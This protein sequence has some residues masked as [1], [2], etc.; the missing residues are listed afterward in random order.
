MPA[1]HDF[2]REVFTPFRLQSVLD[3][4]QGRLRTLELGVGYGGAGEANTASN[5]NVG[6]VGVF[7]QKSGINLEFRGVNVGSSKLSV[8]LDAVNNEIDVDVVEANLTLNN[9]GGTLSTTK[10][11]TGLSSWTAGD[12]PYYASGTAL[13]KLAIGANKTVMQSNGSAPVWNAN[14][15]LGTGTISSGAINGQTISSAANFTGSITAGGD[16]TT[17][18]VF[19]TGNNTAGYS[20]LDNGATRRRLIA[21]GS[22]NQ[23]FIGSYTNNIEFVTYDVRRLTIDGPTGAATFSSSIT[24]G[25]SYI[26]G[27]NEGA[28]RPRSGNDL[29]VGWNYSNGTREIGLWNT[30][31]ANTAESFIFRQLTGTGT[32]HNTLLE[33]KYTGNVKTY[34]NLDLN[35]GTGTISSG[36]INGQTISSAANFTG[37]ITAG[38]NVE[39]GTKNYPTVNLYANAGTYGVLRMLRGGASDWA[40]INPGG[41]FQIYSDARSRNLLVIDS[42]SS[43]ATFDGSITAGGNITVAKSFPQLILNENSTGLGPSVYFD[44]AGVRKAFIAMERIDGQYS[45]YGLAGNLDITSVSGL[46]FSANDG[47][48]NHLRIASTGAA[49]FNG[50]VLLADT[51]AVTSS[52]AAGAFGS[53]FQLD[54]SNGITNQSSLYIDNVFVRGT[55]RAQIFEKNV[56]RFLNGREVVTDSTT[57]SQDTAG[58][59]GAGTQVFTLK[60]AAFLT[61]D[62]VEI[63]DYV[64][65]GGSLSLRA[66][67]GYISAGSGTT[68]VTV[69]YTGYLAPSAGTVW[70]AGAVIGRVGNI[71]NTARQGYIVMDS[72]TTAT[73]RLEFYA[74]RNAYA[75]PEPVIR[76]GQ[77]TS[78]TVGIRGYI[79]GVEVFRID[80]S[81]FNLSGWTG[82]DFRLRK[83][84]DSNNREISLS[85]KPDGS[86]AN[87]SVYYADGSVGA[88]EARW[89]GFGQLYDGT[90][91][92]SD[93]GFALIARNA[94]NSAYEKVMWIS[95][96]EKVIDAFNIG[97]V[98]WSNQAGYSQS[99]SAAQ[100]SYEYGA[101]VTTFVQL[102]PGEN[103]VAVTFRAYESG[104]VAGKNAKFLVRIKAALQSGNSSYGGG[105]SSADSAQFGRNSSKWSGANEVRVLE[106][107]NATIG[108]LTGGKLYQIT[109]HFVAVDTNTGQTAVAYVRDLQLHTGRNVSASQISTAVVTAV[110]S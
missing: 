12:M 52:T 10:G 40:I 44:S 49:T 59:G 51:K 62:I 70:K 108:S 29:A 42:A 68:T 102:L 93:Q 1:L 16:V 88:S 58:Y 101:F 91:W 57:L 30:D 67:V 76:I 63:R 41:N 4:F 86:T 69:T 34:G 7:K 65:S 97:R 19:Q 18:T 79:S 13:S 11:G 85:T 32:T 74:G 21:I 50:N 95:T 81:G 77:L 71:S 89:I 48:T 107:G 98:H 33:I 96:N 27:F 106:N 8:T 104:S 100:V 23:I 43:A 22:S 47:T 26:G 66:A 90:A 24:A 80:N 28:N 55:L 61:D 2:T 105:T 110:D 82:D 83:L 72:N 92:Q 5:V 56:T 94:A 37:S 53:G 3:N 36:A 73:P 6:G 35:G 14:L 46:N 103:S 9:L 39:V 109:I 25:R 64:E 20:G 84:W 78:T 45:W 54:Y 31:V 38:G 87:G 99:E 75:E 17:P 15:D 60:D